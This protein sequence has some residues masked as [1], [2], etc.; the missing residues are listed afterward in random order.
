M[1]RAMMPFAILDGKYVVGIHSSV[2]CPLSN[3]PAMA[4][5]KERRHAIVHRLIVQNYGIQV[6]V[7]TANMEEILPAARLL[8]RATALSPSDYERAK[9]LFLSGVDASN[10]AAQVTPHLNRDPNINVTL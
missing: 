4:C 8:S 1:Q 7:P 2:F 5:T 3:S 6:N 10:L 9:A